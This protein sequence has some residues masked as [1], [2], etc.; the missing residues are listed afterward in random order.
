MITESQEESSDQKV[1]RDVEGQPVNTGV[2]NQ[3]WES[4]PD[5][6]H[7]I[8]PA[9]GGGVKCVHCPGWFCF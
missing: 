4:D 2:W 6:T 3:L 5:C 8:K 7:D 9:S 1:E